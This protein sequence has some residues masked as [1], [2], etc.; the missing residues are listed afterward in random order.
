MRRVI[1]T[2]GVSGPDGTP[3]KW[4]SDSGKSFDT[5]E[6]EWLD[7]APDISC[8][9]PGDYICHR[10]RSPAHGDCFYVM[11]VPGGRTNVEIHSANLAIQLLGCVALGNGTGKFVKGSVMHI[12]GPAGLEVAPLPHDMM[13]VTD[14]RNAIAAMMAD[15]GTDDFM[16]TIQ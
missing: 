6:R 11:N 15:M 12:E 3:G 4:V 10:G 1:L 8:I 7:N 9:P 5:I 2:R 13:G 14:S 16:L